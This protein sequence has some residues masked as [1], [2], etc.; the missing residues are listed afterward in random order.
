M[1]TLDFSDIRVLVAGDVCEDVILVG[2]AARLS[3]DAPGVPIV[4]VEETLHLEACASAAFRQ[5]LALGAV[6]YL[7][8]AGRPALKS[9]LVVASPDADS[10]QVARWDS[11][12]PS[13]DA[14][15]FRALLQEAPPAD[16]L[17]FSQYRRTPPLEPILRAIRR[18]PGLCVVDAKNPGHFAGLD[19]LKVSLDDAWSCLR[20]PRPLRT[21]R[22]AAAAAAALAR[23]YG[24]RMVVIT[25]GRAGYACSCEGAE[26]IE[27][28]LEGA[29]GSTA[30]AGDVFVATLSVALAAK[31]EIRQA[32]KLANL[33]AGLVC[34][35]EDHLPTVSAEE[36]SELVQ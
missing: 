31:H 17:L 22:N 14:E 27:G 12:W 4:S 21:P 9:R 28:G 2:P 18:W 33:A 11:P 29:R 23:S 5:V 15:T 36:I 24:Y 19:V 6:A 35:K 10:R 26:I 3:G 30:G 25:L 32:L 13:Q 1:M 7:I 8:P 20:P 16:V 34:R